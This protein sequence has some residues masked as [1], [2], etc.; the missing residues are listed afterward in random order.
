M[1]RSYEWLA[2]KKYDAV[3]VDK[4]TLDTYAS[5]LRRDRAGEKMNVRA[6]TSECFYSNLIAYLADYSVHQIILA[7]G[8]F[9]FIREQRR[10][11]KSKQDAEAEEA[12]K[13][14]HP[15]SLVISF[16]KKVRFH[17]FLS[18]VSLHLNDDSHQK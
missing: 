16:T 9:V 10:K 18:E 3:M 13:N 7:F 11:L 5:T 17:Y 4:L 6:M 15:G 14:L 2:A 8:Y 1:M 12:E